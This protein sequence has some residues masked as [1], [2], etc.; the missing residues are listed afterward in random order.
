[1]SVIITLVVAAV[2]IIFIGKIN[3]ISFYLILSVVSVFGLIALFFGISFAADYIADKDRRDVKQAV[4]KCVGSIS[5]YKTSEEYFE[6]KEQ[7]FKEQG[8]TSEAYYSSY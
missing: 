2:I 3:D 8:T 1:M 5:A 7:C 4:D 6:V